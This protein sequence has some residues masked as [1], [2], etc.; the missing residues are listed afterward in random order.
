[1]SVDCNYVRHFSNSPNASCHF[2]KTNADCQDVGGFINYIDVSKNLLSLTP[3]SLLWRLRVRRISLSLYLQLYYC[4]FS[5]SHPAA[6]TLSLVWLF[7]LFI[8]LAIA[9][10]D[11]FCPSLAVISKTLRLSQNVAGVTILALGN[12]APD[13][14][15]SLAGIQQARPGK[16]AYAY[17]VTIVVIDNLLL[18]LNYELHFRRRK[19]ITLLCNSQSHVNKILFHTIPI[20]CRQI[21]R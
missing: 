14:F 2:V 8:A 17:R 7:N 13:I 12:G 1:M 18:K 11:F 5:S 21:H 16:Y 9:A 19:N 3:A 15:S 20:Q 10:D 4:N 6:I